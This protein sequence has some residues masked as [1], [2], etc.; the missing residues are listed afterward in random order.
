MEEQRVTLS[1][2]EQEELLR[3]SQSSSLKADMNMLLL[4]GII[5]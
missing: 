1:K 3:L 5:L 2:K 4:T